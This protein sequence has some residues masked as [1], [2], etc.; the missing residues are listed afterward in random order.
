MQAIKKGFL[1]PSFLY[2]TLKTKLWRNTTPIWQEQSF[3]SVEGKKTAFLLIHC[4]PLYFSQEKS[5]A[6][7]NFNDGSFTIIG[8]SIRE[9]QLFHS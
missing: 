5:P 1:A 7:T 3:L 4:I 2:L 6:P 9:N 8:K